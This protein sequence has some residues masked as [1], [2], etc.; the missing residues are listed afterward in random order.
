MG[1][2]P[3]RPGVSRSEKGPPSPQG[4][5]AFFEQDMA[6]S[7]DERKQR[8]LAALGDPVANDFSP[9][10]GLDAPIE[11]LVNWVNAQPDWCTTS[12]CSGRITLYRFANKRAPRP[13]GSPARDAFRASTPA[14]AGET[15]Q[16][17]SP[18]P[19]AGT[20]LG[21]Q[22]VGSGCTARTIPRASMRSPPSCRTVRCALTLFLSS[23][24]SNS[25][26]PQS[27]RTRR[28]RHRRRRRRQTWRCRLPLRAPHHH[29]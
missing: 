21:R 6:L 7:F 12:S 28:C 14:A 9:K 15:Q 26:L 11:E 29:P 16:G 3:C 25:T 1:C 18:L 17:H 8:V 5:V 23:R 13:A 19:H 2:L 27:L 24:R 20:S 4:N 10:G 22:R